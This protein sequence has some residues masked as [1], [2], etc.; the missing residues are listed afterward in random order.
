MSYEANDQKAIA[1][2]QRLTWSLVRIIK[3]RKSS[4][5]LEFHKYKQTYNWKTIN[6]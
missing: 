5:T 2:N 4:S 3:K 1:D 6:H